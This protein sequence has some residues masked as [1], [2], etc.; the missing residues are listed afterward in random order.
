MWKASFVEVII[1]IKYLKS[2][3]HLNLHFIGDHPPMRP[4]KLNK[5]FDLIQSIENI[6]G[7]IPI[8]ALSLG[9]FMHDDLKL[10]PKPPFVGPVRGSCL[11]K[12][13]KFN[14]FHHISNNF[15]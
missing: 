2:Y 13:N 7:N 11:S 12:S 15:F 6:L 8:G 3:I 4:L 5:E 9:S 14:E 1:I 10:V